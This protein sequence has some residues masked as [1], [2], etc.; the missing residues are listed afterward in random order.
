MQRLNADMARRAALDAIAHEKAVRETE[1]RLAELKTADEKRLASERYAK[2]HAGATGVPV[3]AYVA[4]VAAP[5]DPPRLGE[6]PEAGAAW[7]AK[8][9]APAVQGHGA[10]GAAEPSGPTA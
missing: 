1:A 4:P 7:R 6:D 9:G 2:A 3:G 10:A 5:R 8:Y